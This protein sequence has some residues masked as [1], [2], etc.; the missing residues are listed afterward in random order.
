MALK[1]YHIECRHGYFG[2]NSNDKKRNQSL[3]HEYV[4]MKKGMI[5]PHSVVK[6]PSSALQNPSFD[7]IIA[8]YTI[9]HR[10]DR[11]SFLFQI[12]IS[13]YF[14]NYSSYSQISEICHLQNYQYPQNTTFLITRVYTMFSFDHQV[15]VHIRLCNILFLCHCSKND[16]WQFWKLLN[17]FK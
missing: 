6:F 8:P 14:Q 13:N 1:L 2:H 16:S 7:F 10:V 12:S 15:F 9:R 5:Q 4:K 3:N 17:T 11:T